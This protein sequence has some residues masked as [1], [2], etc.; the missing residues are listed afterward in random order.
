MGS[1]YGTWCPCPPVIP[2]P[3]AEEI[4]RQYR[5]L[6]NIPDPLDG[7]Y[8]AGLNRERR[9]NLVARRLGISWDEVW[10]TVGAALGP[11]NWAGICHVR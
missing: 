2:R 7:R 1:R 3:D 10:E 8:N 5:L 6:V 4:L 11:R 9:C